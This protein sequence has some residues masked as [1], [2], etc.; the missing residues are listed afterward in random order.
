MQFVDNIDTGD[1][2]LFRSNNQLG[3]WITRTVTNSSFDHVGI[4]FR[5]GTEAD[6]IYI[7][8]AV[9]VEGVRVTSWMCAR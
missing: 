8:E 4:I 6:D 7:M 1:I 5:F 3:T 9:G 2:I